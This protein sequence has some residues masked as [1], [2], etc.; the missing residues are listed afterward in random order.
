MEEQDTPLGILAVEP[1]WCFASLG[2]P[3]LVATVLLP[4]SLPYSSVWSLIAGSWHRHLMSCPMSLSSLREHVLINHRGGSAHRFMVS[5]L[6]P[7]SGK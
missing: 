2:M 4:A 1:A 3:E 5:V 7:A 6:A